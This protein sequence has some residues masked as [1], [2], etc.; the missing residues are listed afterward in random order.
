M[1]HAQQ[2]VPFP[3]PPLHS[4]QDNIPHIG[5]KDKARLSKRSPNEC[6]WKAD[7]NLVNI[8]ILYL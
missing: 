6:L 8:K 3:F 5:N 7:I 2:H 1:A 4:H